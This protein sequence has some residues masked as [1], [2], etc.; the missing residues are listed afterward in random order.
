[1][2]GETRENP[3]MSKDLLDQIL[4]SAGHD[5]RKIAKEKILPKALDLAKNCLETGMWPIAERKSATPTLAEA[6]ER[7]SALEERLE[8]KV[9][10]HEDAKDLAKIVLNE[11]LKIATKLALSAL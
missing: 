1:M 3:P 10:R 9:K 7:A 5:A 4:E 11:A 2:R 6:I 8:D